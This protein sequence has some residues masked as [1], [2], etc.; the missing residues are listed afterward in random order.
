MRKPAQAKRQRSPVTLEMPEELIEYWRQELDEDARLN[1]YPKDG[2][3]RM[4][5]LIAE[6]FLH[7]QVSE[8]AAKIFKYGNWPPLD[9]A[10][11][12][13]ASGDVDMLRKLVIEKFGDERLGQFVNYPKGKR[14][15]K[16]RPALLKA[17]G[18]PKD[19]TE[20]EKAVRWERRVQQLFK[21][22]WSPQWRKENG[23]TW[24]PAR[25][26]ARFMARDGRPVAAKHD[27]KKADWLEQAIVNQRH[28]KPSKRRTTRK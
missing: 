21:T 10:L 3:L 1:D 7:E 16:L 11:F 17:V 2:N 24:T 8:T 15:Q 14:G 22:D 19:L 27:Q 5:E 26:V 20:V 23:V 25:F 13:A 9:R 6:I 12:L 4:E 18:E 28:K